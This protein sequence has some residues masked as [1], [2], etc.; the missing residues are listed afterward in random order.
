MLQILCYIRLILTKLLW[1]RNRLL[2]DRPLLVTEY[3]TTMKSI[4]SVKPVSTELTFRFW[5]PSTHTVI[6]MKILPRQF[7]LGKSLYKLL[8]FNEI[9]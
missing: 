4:R 3:R 9:R 7:Y 1:T 8:K 2:H 5:A 6:S